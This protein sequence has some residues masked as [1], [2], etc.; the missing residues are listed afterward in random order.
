MK[1]ESKLLFIEF[2][3][4]EPQMHIGIQ[5]T[6][7]NN[8]MV[9]DMFVE[10]GELN[11]WAQDLAAFPKSAGHEA[12]FQYGVRDAEFYAMVRFTAFVHE[13]DGLCA[14]EVIL[15]NNSQRPF[16]N[17]AEFCIRCRQDDIRRLGEQILD[18]DADKNLMMEWVVETPA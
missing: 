9:Q 17:R 1:T 6:D 16:Q 13:K 2:K 18:W 3:D 7:G 11:R 8:K 12:V 5:A 4:D 14:L 15:D 10:R